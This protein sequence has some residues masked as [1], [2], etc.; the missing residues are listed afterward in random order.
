[1]RFTPATG[2]VYGASRER[3][4]S[5]PSVEPDPVI[6]SDD[7]VLYDAKRKTATWHGYAESNGPTL[8]NPG[9]IFAGYDTP[10]AHVSW[11]YLDDECDGFV[12]VTLEVGRGKVLSAHAHL[13]AGPPAFAP[14][15][16][17][18]RVVSDE[19]EQI[20]LGPE[21]EGEVGIEEA[22]EI[23]RRALETVRVM[24]TAVMN[25]NSIDGRPNEASN[26]VGQDANDFGRLFE[27]IMATSLVDKL[28]VIAL[29]ERIFNGLTSGAAPW[30]SDALRRPEEIGDLSNQGRRKMLALMRNAD[31]RALT[32]THRQI[33]TV[34]KAAAAAMFQPAAQGHSLWKRAIASQAIEPANLTAQLHY[35]GVGNPF[36]VLP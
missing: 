6:N 14:D 10:D 5:A 23:V 17:A 34:I 3:H 24:N 31:G 13:G 9:A 4:S 21:V 27:P 18:V 33:N 32:L 12:T 2:K 11:G 30:F 7:L 20:L 29:H 8:T 28:A 19:I 26:M 15:T 1:L 22:E 16:L 35:R 36:S 25:G